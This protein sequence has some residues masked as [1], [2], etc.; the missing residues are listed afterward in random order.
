MQKEYET[1]LGSVSL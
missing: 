1:R